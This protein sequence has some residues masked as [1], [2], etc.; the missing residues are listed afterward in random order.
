MYRYV[1]CSMPRPL[2]YVTPVYFCAQPVHLANCVYIRHSALCGK[3]DREKRQ[4]PP[5]ITSQTLVEMCP[6][7]LLN[8]TIELQNAWREMRELT[9]DTEVV[10]DGCSTEYITGVGRMYEG[11]YEGTVAGWQVP[12]MQDPSICLSLRTSSGGV[13]QPAALLLFDSDDAAAKHS[14]S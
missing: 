12:R 2:H 14:E 3:S 5:L 9:L 8:C 4:L 7:H 10:P 11:L 13:V 1:K 6:P